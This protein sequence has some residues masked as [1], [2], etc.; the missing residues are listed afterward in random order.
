MVSQNDSQT[1]WTRPGVI[2]PHPGLI[3]E[4]YGRDRESTR[5]GPIQPQRS[6]ARLRA[7]CGPRPRSAHTSRVRQNVIPPFYDRQVP[8][9]RS[10]RRSRTTTATSRFGVSRRESHDSSNFYARGLAKIDE[11]K[12][13]TVD[14]AP[15]VNEV[16]VHS[17]EHM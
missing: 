2:S 3:P 14:D 1:P 12:D 15:L 16:F 13:R 4:R 17:A 9:Q 5:F 11:T 8:E 7:D 6:P 10:A